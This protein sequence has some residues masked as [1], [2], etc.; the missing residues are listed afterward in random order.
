MMISC[1][2]ALAVLGVVSVV[3][4]APTEEPEQIISQENEIQPDG[5]FKWSFE[6][7]DGTKQEQSGQPKEVGFSILISFGFL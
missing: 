7:G 5:S 6:T 4:C 1:K 3:L 2:F